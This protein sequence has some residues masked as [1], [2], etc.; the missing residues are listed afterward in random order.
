MCDI[1][2]YMDP[3]PSSSRTPNHTKALGLHKSSR[4]IMGPPKLRPASLNVPNIQTENRFEVL[5]SHYLSKYAKNSSAN[6]AMDTAAPTANYTT[7]SD[8]ATKSNV[9]EKFRQLLVSSTI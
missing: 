7:T 8:N 1:Y 2:D 4:T 9:K 6:T 5:N 3:E